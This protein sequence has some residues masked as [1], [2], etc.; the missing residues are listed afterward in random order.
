MDAFTTLMFAVFAVQALY[1][2]RLQYQLNSFKARTV[3]LQD[4]VED[5]IDGNV[6]VSRTYNGFQV[7]P[8]GE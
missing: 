5:M 3:F 8:K 7:T 1:I 6:V 2:V 4:I